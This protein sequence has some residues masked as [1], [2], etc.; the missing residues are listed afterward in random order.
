MFGGTSEGG[1]LDDANLL[2]AAL[3]V[4]TIVVVCACANRSDW[5][6]EVH[7]YG[8]KVVVTECHRLDH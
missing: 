2:T 6:C 4:F 8:N 5:K 3:L 7:R 1:K